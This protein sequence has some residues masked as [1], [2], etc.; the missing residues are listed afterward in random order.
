MNIHTHLSEC[1]SVDGV[2]SRV[3]VLVNKVPI[4]LSLAL[5]SL[6]S[7]VN[8]GRKVALVLEEV[9][10]GEREGRVERWR[11][12]SGGSWQETEGRLVRKGSGRYMSTSPTPTNRLTQSSCQ[13]VALTGGGIPAQLSLRSS[14]R[15]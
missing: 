7:P 11:R 3:V 4:L 12:E 15:E 9:G 2:R 5:K 10:R 14:S 13:V 1:V 8:V 6:F